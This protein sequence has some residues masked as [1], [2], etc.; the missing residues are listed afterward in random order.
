MLY[1]DHPNR[2]SNSLQNFEELNIGGFDFSN[3]FRCCD[4]HIFEKLNSLSINKFELNFYQDKNK[5]KHNLIPIEISK[6]DSGKVIDV[7]LYKNFYAL[8]KKLK[9]I[10]GDHH[11][12]FICRRCLN[13]YKSEN[14]LMIHKPKRENNDITTIRNSPESHLHWKDHFHKNALYFRIYADFEADNEKDNSSVGSKTTQIY[15]QN[16]VL[17]GYHIESEL[18]CVS[19][20]GYYESPLGFYNVDW[21]VDEVSKI[22]K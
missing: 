18:Y 7:L 1:L 16:P 2:V 11:K 20:S 21:F 5:W 22:R 13:S 19:H 3:G 17:N 15:K 4:V 9:A 8:I 6:N 12:N 14:M 10:L